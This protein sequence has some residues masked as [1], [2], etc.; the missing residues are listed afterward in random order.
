MTNKKD[1]ELVL[2]AQQGNM[3]AI[4]EI[5]ERY[6]ESL[7]YI[8]YQ[9]TNNSDD[10]EDAL[11]DTFLQVT[12]SINQLKKPEFLKLWLNRIIAGKC[13]NIFRSN[14]TISVDISNHTI[15][16][17]Y[18]EERREFLPEQAMRFTSDKDVIDYFIMQLPQLQQEALVMMYAQDLT[19]QQIADQLHEPIGT[20]KS[21][22]HLAK[23]TL[24]KNISAYESREGTKLNFYSSAYASLLTGALL[25]KP[26]EKSFLLKRLAAFHFTVSNAMII[27]CVALIFTTGGMAF[28]YHG[29][30]FNTIEPTNTLY[31]QNQTIRSDQ[32]A[33]FLLMNWAMNEQQLKYKTP[34][35][36][37]LYK[38]LYEYLKEHN[39]IYYQSLKANGFDKALEIYF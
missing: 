35:E 9:I 12:K 30:S 3:D 29:K 20:I 21:R 16:R 26:M 8:A 15:H 28:Y 36:I 13:K 2:A 33:Y 5:F 10:A 19:M 18:L 24:K 14:K 39:S 37:A 31:F 6:R 7:F 25:S 34:E 22:I 38:P 4:S 23:K 32:S 17:R 27:S 1:E 11:Q